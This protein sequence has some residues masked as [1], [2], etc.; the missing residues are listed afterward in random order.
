[1]TEYRWLALGR[2]LFV[3]GLVAMSV[4]AVVFEAVVLWEA[5]TYP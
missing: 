3:G 4:L 1:M 5:V 2:A